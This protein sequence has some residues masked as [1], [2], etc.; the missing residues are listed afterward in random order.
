MRL[1][2][3]AVPIRERLYGIYKLAALNEKESN[4]L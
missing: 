2:I 3:R 1:K 4:G